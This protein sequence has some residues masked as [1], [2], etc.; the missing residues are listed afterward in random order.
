MV[1]SWF[2]S[3]RY[4]YP[5]NPLR[6]T[7]I[8]VSVRRQFQL[9]PSRRIFPSPVAHRSGC[10]IVILSTTANGRLVNPPEIPDNKLHS[11]NLD[12]NGEL[13]LNWLV[14][15][16]N[17]QV[18][19]YVKNAFHIPDGRNFFYLGFSQRGNAPNSDL[20]LFQ[21]RNGNADGVT[22]SWDGVERA[23]GP[24]WVK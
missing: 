16:A 17:D 22:V 10:S 24:L 3:S 14:D 5:F 6:A 7:T 15:W 20:C 1:V 23:G 4:L 18:F 12:K 2:I 8:S 11:V 13:Q 19:F 9:F 21:R